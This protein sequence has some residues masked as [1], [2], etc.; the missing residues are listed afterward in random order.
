MFWLRTLIERTIDTCALCS[1]ADVQIIA[2]LVQSDHMYLEHRY[3]LS[4]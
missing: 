1:F 2:N 3:I 4:Q